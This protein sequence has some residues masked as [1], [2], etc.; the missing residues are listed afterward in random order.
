MTQR[1]P[2]RAG[3]FP[4]GS[5][6]SHD[7]Y[8][9]SGKLLLR[10][11]T[12]IASEHQVEHLEQMGYFDPEA[13]D[14]HHV[15]AER[16]EALAPQGY[17]PE[18][19]SGPLVS[20]FAELGY[21]SERLE[22]AYASADA[23]LDAEI[24]SIAAAI[25]RCCALD[26][27][28]SLAHLLVPL[29]FQ[30][31]VRHPVNVAVLATVMLARQKFDE[32]QVE[33]TIAACLTMNI[34]ALDLHHELYYQAESITDFQRG[35]IRAHPLASVQVLRQRG[36]QDPLW[37][38]IVSQHHE[39]LDGSGYPA[40]ISGAQIRP[41]AQVVSLADRYCAMIS[42]RA[43]REPLLPTQALKDIH[44]RHGKSI[45]PALI[46][47][48]ISAMGLYPPGTLVRLANGE[49]AVVVHR[50]L[51]PRNPVVYAL[52]PSSGTPYDT[53]R[54]RLTASQPAYAISDVLP[55]KAV[56]AAIDQEKLW[57]PTATSG[58][59]VAAGAGAA[60]GH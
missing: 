30:H 24:R 53:P 52:C 9:R 4:I 14:I 5:T 15:A 10:R 32:N 18:R 28:A 33:A 47:G 26:A 2:V 21:A 45:A 50:L 20:V 16:G 39:A 8:D 6:L 7:I 56:S 23:N 59:P 51:D 49:A 3:Q 42:E 48:L 36:V 22:R 17:L 44:V 25:R 54:K 37:L 46:S 13:V 55:R 35:R 57:P 60:R 31:T 29:P 38:Q 58:A 19:K 12:A 43:S 11:G 34:G 1:I 40:G 41:E 27:D